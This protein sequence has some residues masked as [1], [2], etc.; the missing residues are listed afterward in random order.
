MNDIDNENTIINNN[1][2]DNILNVTNSENDDGGI[3]IEEEILFDI[4]EDEPKKISKRCFWQMFI[5]LEVSFVF[6]FFLFFLNGCSCLNSLNALW[7][8]L[9]CSILLVVWAFCVFY[10]R[11]GEQVKM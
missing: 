11:D 3:I 5:M 6:S 9:V 8:N 7:F 2:N 10:T 1:G 4:E